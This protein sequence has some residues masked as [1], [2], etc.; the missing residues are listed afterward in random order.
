VAH[1][2]LTPAQ[3]TLFLPTYPLHRTTTMWAL[4]GSLS[5]SVVYATGVWVRGV[6]FA[7][8]LGC[9]LKQNSPWSPRVH[10]IRLG[11]SDSASA[12]ILRRHCNFL[13]VCPYD[14]RLG[15]KSKLFCKYLYAWLFVLMI[16]AWF[17]SLIECDELWSNVHNCICIHIVK[18]VYKITSQPRLSFNKDLSYLNR[19]I[20]S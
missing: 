6:S 7:L 20:L 13:I 2:S 5:P 15:T 16:I 12:Q 19:S 11:V 1:S 18:N 14:N 17:D 10:A 8:H 4:W 3:P 9:R